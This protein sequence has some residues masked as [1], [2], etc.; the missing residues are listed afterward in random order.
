MVDDGAGGALPEPQQVAYHPVTGVP[1]EF[2]E[3]LHKDSEE[4]KKLKAF[5]GSEADVS[6]TADKVASTSLEVRMCCERVTFREALSLRRL[7]TT[8]T[9]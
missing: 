2:H 9:S 6:D 7:P 5:K 3:Y 1:E 4:Y 8:R